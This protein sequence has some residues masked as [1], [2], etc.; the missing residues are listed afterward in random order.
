MPQR[1]SKNLRKEKKKK[2]IAPIMGVSCGVG[3]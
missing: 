2:K 3:T 1:V